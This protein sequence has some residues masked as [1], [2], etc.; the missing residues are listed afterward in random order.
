MTK[1]QRL[2]QE[3]DNA[4][5]SLLS[6]VKPRETVLYTLKRTESRD[7]TSRRMDCYVIGEGKQLVNV[8]GLVATLLGWPLNR[9][10]VRVDGIGSNPRITLCNAI[11]NAL[12]FPFNSI[13]SEEL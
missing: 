10:G 2:Q 13:P 9:N 8:S 7:G 11:A 12:Q 3:R 4:K 6:I 5:Q 1:K